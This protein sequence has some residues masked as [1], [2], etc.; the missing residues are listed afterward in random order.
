MSFFDIYLVPLNFPEHLAKYLTIL[1]SSH[2][3]EIQ[4]KKT[5]VF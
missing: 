5:E 3:F 1:Q 2:Y 4:N